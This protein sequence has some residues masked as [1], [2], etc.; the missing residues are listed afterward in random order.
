[1]RW[2]NQS[3]K[4]QKIYMA[5]CL[6]YVCMML[7]EFLRVGRS[8]SPGQVI[9]KFAPIWGIAFGV[10]MLVGSIP[11]KKGFMGTVSGTPRLLGIPMGIGLILINL[12][13]ILP[14]QEVLFKIALIVFGAGFIL[15]VVSGCRSLW[16]YYKKEDETEKRFAKRIN[17]ESG[18]E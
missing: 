4:R 10:V 12:S 6:L 7:W 11:D 18:S 16:A 14:Q 8:P 15:A 3:S 17:K 9:R 1:M 13:A 5:V 2:L